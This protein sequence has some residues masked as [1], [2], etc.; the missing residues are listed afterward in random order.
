MKKT[1]TFLLFVGDQCGK[2]QEAIDF[3]T[4]IFP[5][6]KTISLEKYAEGEAGGAPD[7]IKHGVFTINETEYMVSESNFDHAFTF[8][9]AISIFVEYDSE[10]EMKTYFEKLSKGGQV[11]VPIDDYGYSHSQKYGWCEDRFGVSWQFNLAK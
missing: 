2:A 3:Y 9:P 8:S 11:M 7:L 5:N 1:S 4:S 10:D 6:S